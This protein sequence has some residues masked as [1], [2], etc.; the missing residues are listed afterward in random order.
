MYETRPTGLITVDRRKPLTK[1]LSALFLPTPDQCD[2]LVTGL[3]PNSDLGS[4]SGAG[5]RVGGPLHLQMTAHGMGARYT[6]ASSQNDYFGRF[7]PPGTGVAIS[8]VSMFLLAQYPVV[9]SAIAS[10][11]GVGVSDGS[12]GFTFR[13]NA[14]GA[15]RWNC[16]SSGGNTP[17]VGSTITANVP[18]SSLG[19]WNG[20]TSILY[21]A[22]QQ[23]ATGSMTGTI[24]VSSSGTQFGFG[25]A[26]G[27]SAWVD[28]II[29]MCAIWVGR[30]LTPQDAVT[31]YQKPFS[32]FLMDPKKYYWANTVG[33]NISLT[34]SSA[35]LTL[36]GN[37][38]VAG[39]GVF[40]SAGTL[41]LTGSAPVIGFG[42]FPNAGSLILTGN[43]PQLG[44]G[45]FPSAGLLSL[46]G[47]AP[48]MGLGFFPP[49]GN[50]VITGLAPTLAN[51][52][53]LSPGAGSLTLNGNAPV[54][55]F[56]LNPAA[57]SLVITGFAP[58]AVTGL[59]FFP[60]AGTLS[61]NG[62]APIIG[63]GMF[64]GAGS[65]V[66]TGNA[67]TLANNL[68][69]TPGSGVLTLNGLTPVIGFGMFPTAGS[70]VLTGV[71]PG[72]NV[73]FNLTPASGTLNLTGLTPTVG[74]SYFFS[75][76]SGTLTLTGN[77]PFGGVSYFLTPPSGSLS[78]NG[79]AAKLLIRHAP[80]N[81]QPDYVFSFWFSDAIEYVGYQPVSMKMFIQYLDGNQAL[82]LNVDRLTL[83]RVVN[84][85]NEGISP[86]NILNGL[87]AV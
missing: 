67:P 25:G 74:I 17:V 1:G 23:K 15:N 73:G 80:I 87:V 38:P 20:T 9:P 37:A 34:P 57:G 33:S 7:T 85:I 5:A 65:F 60:G 71:T 55:G 41:S 81:F 70:L 30:T 19:T 54:M 27:A 35:A 50:L 26:Q 72:A 13:C 79:F 56:G 28:V 76:P 47:N 51:N 42:L 82:Y 64:P 68:G 59:S 18:L 62:S 75:P 8:A 61:L 14:S 78:L 69:L 12:Q 36:T 40:P 31:L 29:L 66:L 86:N 11:A 32:S 22:G 84:S 24:T 43:A 46:T 10:V 53:G 21:E 83:Q 52:L 4:G 2:D 49:S 48:V 3:M 16:T 45:F 77:V 58:S 63:F 6:K 44:L 39:T